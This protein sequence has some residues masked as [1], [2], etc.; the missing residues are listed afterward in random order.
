MAAP[1][2][3]KRRLWD[4]Y[5]LPGFRPEAT[6]RGVFGDPKARIIKLRRRSKKRGAVVVDAP[7]TAGT[8]VRSVASAI[9]RAATRA[10]LSNSKCDA[11]F[12]GV[13]AK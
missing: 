9:Y 4:V 8:I 11:F 13:A 6:L 3:R 7:T 5:A 10:Y 12:A 1:A 2:T